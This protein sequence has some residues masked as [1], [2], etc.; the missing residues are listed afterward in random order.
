MPFFVMQGGGI[1]FLSLED[2]L[3]Y[4]GMNWNPWNKR[5]KFDTL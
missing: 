3:P 4:L 5:S 1:L 2:N